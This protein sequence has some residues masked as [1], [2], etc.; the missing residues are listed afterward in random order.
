M[1]I[2]WNKF[3]Y[4]GSSISSTE[5]DINRQLV[6]AW[7]AIDRLSVIWKS[8]LSDKIKCSFFHV[9]VVSILLYGCTTWT[10]IK[11]MEKKLDSNYTRMLQA[12]LNKSW[13]QQ[14]TKQQLSSY[15]PPILKTIQIRRTRHVG[16]CWR[17]KDVLMSDVLLWT[18]S[19]R[20]AS[21][22]QSAKTYLQQHCTDTGCSL[23]DLP[24]V[25]D[26]KDEWQERVREIHVG[27]TTWWWW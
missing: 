15:L 9:A 6:N 16:H 23:E 19:H 14:P 21:V 5:N 4:L 7:T 8:D 2:L 26:N 20:W 3:N 10:L 24:E 13:R 17:S 25:M 1:G 12:I 11:C 27:C 22:G 18:P